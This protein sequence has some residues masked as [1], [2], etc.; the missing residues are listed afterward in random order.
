[1]RVKEPARKNAILIPAL[2]PPESLESYIQELIKENFQYIILVDDGSDTKYKEFF[3]RIEAKNSGGG[4]NSCSL[5][6]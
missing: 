3:Q 6:A 2:N 1:M 5:T 4:A